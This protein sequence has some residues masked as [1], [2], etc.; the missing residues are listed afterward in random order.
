MVMDIPYKGRFCQLGRSELD[1][2]PPERVPS[3]GYD[4]NCAM[5]VYIYLLGRVLRRVVTADSV[6]ML[7]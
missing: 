1:R 3:G 7:V 2:G 6:Y 4:W 5:L